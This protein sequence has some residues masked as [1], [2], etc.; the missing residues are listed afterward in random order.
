VFWWRLQRDAVDVIDNLCASRL[1]DE[2][3]LQ[4]QTGHQLVDV[5]GEW[6]QVMP[7]EVGNVL[8]IPYVACLVLIQGKILLSETD[9]IEKH[10]E[11]TL[12]SLDK[13]VGRWRSVVLHESTQ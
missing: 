12:R 3:L 9:S 10:V 2:R 7:H 13:T 8:L 4:Y 6:L 5:A 1:V 11:T